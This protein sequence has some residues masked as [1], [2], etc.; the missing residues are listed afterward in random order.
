M[1][2]TLRESS[3]KLAFKFE[4]GLISYSLVMYKNRPLTEYLRKCVSASFRSKLLPASISAHIPYF[5]EIGNFI[6]LSKGE[7]L[8]PK[9]KHFTEIF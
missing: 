9:K 4:T 2:T 5:K 3:M 6:S 8:S 1:I 7:T